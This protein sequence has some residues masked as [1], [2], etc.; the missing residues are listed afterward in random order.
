MA[1]GS[2][3]TVRPYDPEVELLAMRSNCWLWLLV[4]SVTKMAALPMVNGPACWPPHGAHKPS[5]S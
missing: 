5:A 1:E 4:T 2:V 3:T